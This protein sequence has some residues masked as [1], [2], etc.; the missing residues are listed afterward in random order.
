MP[1]WP[2]LWI[3]LG[4]PFCAA[5]G[6]LV[7][8]R[9]QGMMRAWASASRWLDRAHI[10]TR[11]E[12]E[13]GCG[14]DLLPN[15]IPLCHRCHHAMRRFDPGEEGDGF[16]WLSHVPRKPARWQIFTDVFPWDGVGRWDLLRLQTTLWA[17]GLFSDDALPHPLEVAAVAEQDIASVWT[18]SSSN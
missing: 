10:I 2:G 18:S 3:G 12:C 16:R 15:L 5:C 4:E 13:R 8:E 6:W 17:L 11:D 1:R 9:D 14:L 7:P